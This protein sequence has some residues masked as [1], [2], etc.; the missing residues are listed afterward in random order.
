M[1]PRRLVNLKVVWEALQLCAPGFSTRKT[2][3]HWHVTYQERTYRALPLGKH[4][5][6]RNAEIEVGHV[7]HMARFL[8]VFECVSRQLD[9]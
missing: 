1:G 9:I 7:R 3:H 6:R 4:G 8:G 5:H 2:D